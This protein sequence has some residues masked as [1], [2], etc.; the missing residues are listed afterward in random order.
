MVFLASKD[1]GGTHFDFNAS[2]FVAGRPSGNGQDSNAEFNLAFSHALRGKLAI[3]GEI[4]GDTRLNNSVPGFASTLWAMTYN[5]TP[6]LVVDAG[7]DTALTSN[8]P[9]HKRFVMGFVYSIG[10]LYPRIRRQI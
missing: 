6:R 4:Y 10:E 9:F 3:T 1:V 8:A 7:M 5:L 2:A